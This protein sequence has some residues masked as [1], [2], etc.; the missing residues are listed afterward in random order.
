LS[1]S[2]TLVEIRS[3]GSLFRHDLESAE[4]A[5]VDLDTADQLR[6]GETDIGTSATAFLAGDHA[7]VANLSD[8]KAIHRFRAEGFSC[9]SDFTAREESFVDLAEDESALAF[10]RCRDD[11]RS[12]LQVARGLDARP[13]EEQ[14]D[15]RYVRP[16]TVSIS[17]GGRTIVVGFSSGQVG[18][19]RDGAWVE[20]DVL[21]SDRFPHNDY[22]Q[23]WASIDPGGSFVVTR[24]DSAG[25]ELWAL[26]GDTVQR[27]AKLADD[28]LTPQPA[29]AQFD[30][31]SA[32]VTISWNS[33]YGRGSTTNAVLAKSWSFER[34][35]LTERACAELVG[36]APEYA[37]SV[38]VGS[39]TS[40]R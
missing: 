26:V 36:Q 3:D 27:L 6:Y 34:S 24:L 37:T 20:P 11:G 40:C 38:G 23:G 35:F 17:D 8:G 18:I 15:L 30:D 2:Q 21:Q 12:V 32:R 7:V 5:Q 39:I 33:P 4:T 22:Q 16:S 19:L 10:V 25:V 29:F 28:D 14:F 13:V 1:D 9:S 31:Q